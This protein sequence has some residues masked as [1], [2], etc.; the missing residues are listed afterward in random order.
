VRPGAGGGVTGHGTA[1][2]CS[3]GPNSRTD[4]LPAGR[5]NFGT[6][7]AT[8]A[9]GCRPMVEPL[10]SIGTVSWSIAA[11]PVSSPS[12]VRYL[13]LAPIA[14][15]TC[16]PGSRPSSLDDRASAAR[17]NR[18]LTQGIHLAGLC[19]HAL[20]ISAIRPRMRSGTTTL[21]WMGS[22]FC[23]ALCLA[24]AV[25]LTVGSGERGTDLALQATA[26]LSFLLFWP[27]YTGGAM[28]ALFGGKFRPLKAYTREFGLSF[29][30]AHLVHV[31]LIGWLC[32]IGDAP[33]RGTFIF[34]GIA[35]GWTYLIALASI[36]RLQRMLGS[37][38]WWVL[39]VVGLNY[40]AYAFGVDFFSKP[41]L[42][43]AK[44]IVGYLPFAVLTVAG[45]T[46]RVAAFA[47]R[48]RS[49]QKVAGAKT[50]N[51]TLRA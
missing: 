21:V 2:A 31:G 23:A 45:P 41:L 18:C 42:T 17:A 7:I 44:H 1:N 51:Q 10:R 19:G 46:L 30:S 4:R 16:G 40:I 49:G 50:A 15:P 26:R 14:S 9:T 3:C 28:A 12:R 35:L 47:L 36:G 32:W 8:A 37:K 48:E 24:A 5:G 39:R 43:D 13:Q 38:G 11:G 6:R 22:A 27:A 34:F 25:L 33:D 20:P 29:A